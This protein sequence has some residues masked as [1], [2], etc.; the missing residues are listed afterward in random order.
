[1]KKEEI[2]A[3][4]ESQPLF[5]SFPKKDLDT[6]IRLSR[7]KTYPKDEF[8]FHES[9]PREAL[10]I[11]LSGRLTILQGIGDEM[12][13]KA[14]YQ[15]GSV[16]SE[17]ILRQD[18]SPHKTSGQAATALKTLELDLQGLEKLRH[19]H[20]EIFD[21]LQTNAYKA[22][23][24][25]MIYVQSPEGTETVRYT[26][27]EHDLLGERDVPE[28]ALY[29]I[30]TLRALE[31]FPISRIGISKIPILVKSL[32]MVK[33]AAAMANH[34][35][36]KLDEAV[37][38]AIIQACDEIIDGSHHE[39]FVVD[40][41]QGGAGTSTNMNANE[42]IANRALEIMGHKRGNYEYC[43]PNNHVNLSQS[44]NDVYPTALRIAL[45][46]SLQL[47]TGAMK[48]LSKAFDAKSKEFRN[49][50]KM[51][52][53]QL[54]DAVPMTLGQEFSTFSIMIN[55][56]IERVKELDKL[57][58]E[59][60]M[61]A[62]AIGTGLNADPEYTEAVRK[63]LEVI[64]GKKM[65]TAKNLVE[66]TQDTGAYVQVSGVLKRVATKLNKICNDLRLL[67]SGP[68]AGLHEINLPPVQPGSSI[69][70][71]KVNPVI[72]EVVNQVA[73]EVIGNDV[74]ITMAAG[75]GQLQ[76]NVMEPVIAWSLFKS[77]SHLRQ[78][79]IVLAERTVRNI[80][81]NPDVTRGYVERSIG[82]VTALLPRLGYEMCSTL[83]REALEKGKSIRE[84]VL[85]KNLMSETELDNILK[86]EAMIR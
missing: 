20:R 48:Q 9:M 16:I 54:Q 71:G 50:I 41:Y 63:H 23:A 67:S 81:A 34:E 35:L 84:I 74:T 43:H 17:Q 30:Q 45:R 42:V 36:G 79:C 70:P 28:E 82:I 56:D 14:M 3:I 31:N 61:G 11:I 32:A 77:I 53:T 2:L 49:I 39:A 27:K 6:V 12:M 15:A 18:H 26:R 1:M 83:A 62:T 22:F 75:A 29:G 40:V 66:A 59:I 68:R 13:A 52:R 69:M 44:T 19:R 25:S 78:A 8:L 55:E 73:F 64:T 85:D 51:G 24:H 47:L 60:N 72:P 76:L 5:K 4:L 21:R 57:L 10:Y 33:K 46:F 65:T 38:R 37:A 58:E 86:P 80:T 7:V